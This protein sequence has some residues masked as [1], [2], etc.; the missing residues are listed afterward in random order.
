M[1]RSEK[2]IQNFGSLIHFRRGLSQTFRV[3]FLLEI[4][5]VRGELWLQLQIGKS[6]FCQ[7][8]I[9]DGLDPRFGFGG[10]CIDSGLNVVLNLSDRL[11]HSDFL[12]AKEERGSFA[13][14][15]KTKRVRD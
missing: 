14:E 4:G 5:E 10:K 6:H 3:N 7:Y 15:G 13:L 2:F 12:V 11:L 8:H 1:K 9:A